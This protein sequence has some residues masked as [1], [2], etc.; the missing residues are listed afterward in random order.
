MVYLIN[1]CETITSM[2]VVS[3]K[4]V[5]TATSETNDNEIINQQTYYVAIVA[6]GNR[7]GNE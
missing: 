4:A 7:T 2:Y 5:V 3:G 6:A 1:N